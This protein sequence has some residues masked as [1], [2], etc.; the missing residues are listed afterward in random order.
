MRH[1]PD[2]SFSDLDRPSKHPV[3]SSSLARASPTLGSCR[4]PGT[5]ALPASSA[6]VT[7]RWVTGVAYS[8]RLSAHS[9]RLGELCAQQRNLLGLHARRAPEL[10]IFE[11]EPLELLGVPLLLE[12]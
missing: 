5:Y 1:R 8:Q 11:C 9:L 12:L 6:A 3:A 4:R 7:P 2:I 10:V